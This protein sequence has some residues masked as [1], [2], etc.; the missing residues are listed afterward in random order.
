MKK[1]SIKYNPYFVATEIRVDGKLPKE[2]S[3]LNVGNCR[4]QEWV[5]KL[6]EILKSEY[7]D[8]NFEIVFTGSQAD[9]EDVKSAF[10]DVNEPEVVFSHN[11][12][13]EITEVEKEIDRI[14][15]EIQDGPLEDLKDAN[16]VETFHRAKNQQFEVNVVATMSSGKSTLINALL[17]QTLMP[18][19]NEATTATIVRIIDTDQPFFS[20]EAYDKSGNKVESVPEV[21]LEK[22]RKLN[23][24]GQI[25]IV[26]LRGKIPFVSSSDI[27][28][29]LVDTPGP[30]NSRDKRHREMTYRMLENSAHSLVLYVMNATQ[31]GIND[32][33][34]FLAYVCD[35]MKQ[36]G[37][38]S[39]DRFIFVV[40]K[41][42]SFNPLQEGNECITKTLDAVNRNLE[43]QNIKG[44][45]IF[46]VSAAS[47]LSKRIQ[48]QGPFAQWPRFK[49]MYE[50]SDIFC[51]ENYHS[52][53]HLPLS[54]KKDIEEKGKVAGEDGCGEIH[55]GIVSIE[56]AINLYINKYA[57]TTKIYALVQSF[58]DKL[59]ELCA[60][61]HLQEAIRKDKEAREKLEKQ[62]EVI[63][64]N[65]ET[66][67]EA[68]AVSK[69][70]DK[71]ELV[72]PVKTEIQ[73][74]MDPII[75]EIQN[76]I[77]KMLSGNNKIEKQKALDKCQ[78]LEIKCKELS[79]QVKLKLE[80]IL[81]NSYQQ[82]ITT[83]IN[84]Y[85]QYL[86]LLNMGVDV[87]D[88]NINSLDLVGVALA[89]LSQVIDTN[90]ERKDESYFVK[91]EYQKYVEGGFVR[92]SLNWLTWGWVEQ[93]YYETAYRNKRIEKNVDYVDMKEVA[94]EYFL[95]FQVYLKGACEKA[96]HYVED[97][98]K[99]LKEYLKGEL[100]KID[101]LLNKKLDELTYTEADSKLKEE[102]IARKEANLKWMEMIQKRVN[103]IIN[104]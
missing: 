6:P 101:D 23:E 58:N 54:I 42:D 62:I 71:V 45:N 77:Q 104:I 79:I 82:T 3:S 68:G 88:L 89:D 30:N 11:K 93:G 97:E 57:R 27:K 12:I 67:R 20:A 44:A 7:H 98:T 61:E 32:D 50:Y 4:L 46:P 66:A 72:D 51:F 90:T 86:S 9:F 83:I 81:Q 103:D 73:E 21:T 38:Q 59:K 84:E 94:D 87:A 85:K 22:M 76:E 53:S 49:Q 41:M 102:E 35:N 40:N 33:A 70:I 10:E 36:K 1:V 56:Q 15:Q 25:S 28:L 8:S 2:N 14:F 95:P 99:R 18:A 24:N 43:E 80:H 63:R 29:V 91:E 48:E 34:T 5:E 39:K 47:A 75:L 65:I 17:G 92:K 37:K 19:A 60:V 69:K 74:Y 31:L 100:V 55:T 96:F 26:E 64:T 16:I 78:K 52:Y 13:P